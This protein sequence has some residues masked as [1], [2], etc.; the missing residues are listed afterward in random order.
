MAAAGAQQCVG[1]ELFLLSLAFKHLKSLSF[2]PWLPPDA[3]TQSGEGFWR[4]P[5]TK[6]S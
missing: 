1:F 5:F 6:P 4:I 3:G 2:S